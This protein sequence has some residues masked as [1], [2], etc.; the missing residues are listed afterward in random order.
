[1]GL[2]A[3]QLNIVLQLGLVTFAQHPLVAATL[4][5]AF[6]DGAS[7]EP[8]IHGDHSALYDQSAPHVLQ[9]RDLI[10]ASPN[11]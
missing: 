11:R 8:G 5:E 7:G 3:D 4:H 6:G 1:V 10:R 9:D 2:V